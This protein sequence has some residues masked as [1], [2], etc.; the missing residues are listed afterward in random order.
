MGSIIN[1]IARSIAQE[2][3]GSGSDYEI[4][5]AT[6]FAALGDATS[7]GRIFR[8]Q[9]SGRL[10]KEITVGSNHWWLPFLETLDYA[11]AYVQ[12]TEAEDCKVLY[13]DAAIPAHYLTAN[14]TKSGANAPIVLATGGGT[15][16]IS[17]ELD[18]VSNPTRLLVVVPYLFPDASDYAT[19]YCSGN[20]NLLPR[21][22]YSSS[23]ADVAAVSSALDLGGNDPVAGQPIYMFSNQSASTSKTIIFCPDTPIGA[24]SVIGRASLE[25]NGSGRYF[26][27][28]GFAS[29]STIQIRDIFALELS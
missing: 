13:G 22:K 23:S 21:I 4:N 15:S 14:A 11:I 12:D 1:N 8:L 16:Y 18:S 19:A 9:S 17:A 10:I 29:T 3:S 24:E 26:G 28:T 27:I 2:S 25:N 20:A 5:D 7:A 6:N